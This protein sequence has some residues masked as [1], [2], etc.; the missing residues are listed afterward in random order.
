MGVPL[1]RRSG[2]SVYRES[3]PGAAVAGV[4]ESAWTGL[5]GC[6]RP[7]RVFPDGCVDLVWDGTVLAAVTTVRGVLRHELPPAEWTAGLR[8]KCGVGGAVLGLPM[9][10]LSAGATPLRDLWAAGARRAESE[11]AGC[12]TPGEARSVLETLIAERLRDVEVD[13]LSLAAARA[14]RAPGARTDRVAAELGVSERGLRRHMRHDVGVGPK[15][16]QRVLRFRRFLERVGAVGRGQASLADVAA[17]VGYADQSHL[18]RECRRLSGTSPG[19][20]V[21]SWTGRN[22]P[23]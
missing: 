23:D 11:L 6:R 10:E 18:G 8:L 12:G 15:E 9:T 16:L 1:R 21:R 20:L 17:D 2:R 14:L 19:A 3:T 5:V 4:V 22:V 7:L 13:G